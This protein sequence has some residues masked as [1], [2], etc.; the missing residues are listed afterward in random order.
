MNIIKT[1]PVAALV[2]TTL[3]A[4]V[5]LKRRHDQRSGVFAQ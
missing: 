4:T 2:A 5:S 3:L 1:L